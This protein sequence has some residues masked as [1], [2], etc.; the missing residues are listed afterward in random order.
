MRDFAPITSFSFSG[1]LNMQRSELPRQFKKKPLHAALLTS[2][3]ALFGAGSIVVATTGCTVKPVEKMLDKA[4]AAVNPCNPCAANPCAAN[5]CNPCNPCAANP[6][7]PCA[8]NPCNPCAAKACNPCNPCAANPCNPCAANPCNPCAA[9]PC[10]PCCV[11]NPCNP[12][13]CL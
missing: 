3:L 1:D 5:P 9:N 7:N 6:C 10:N 4:S 2:T 11:K 12:C 13:A 8:A